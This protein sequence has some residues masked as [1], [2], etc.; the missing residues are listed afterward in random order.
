LVL[1]T[2]QNKQELVEELKAR[3][4]LYDGGKAFHDETESTTPEM[5]MKN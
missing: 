2:Q 5:R 4:A 3:V 1:A